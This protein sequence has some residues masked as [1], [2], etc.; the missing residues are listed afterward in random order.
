MARISQN[1]Q[2]VLRSVLDS[3]KLAMVSDGAELLYFKLLL[4][5]DSEGRYHGSAF[6]VMARALTAKA[7]TGVIETKMVEGWLVE[8]AEM[9]L[10]ER[11]ETEGQVYLRILDYFDPTDE[12]RKKVMFP[13]PPQKPASLGQEGTSE[14]PG[15][16]VPNLSPSR[17]QVGDDSW[18]TCPD[19]SP[20]T[21]T[22]TPT[23]HP[24]PSRAR[25]TRGVSVPDPDTP[26]PADVKSRK[27]LDD[28]VMQAEAAGEVLRSDLIEAM[29][30]YRKSCL[31]M[32]HPPPSA[33]QW[34]QALVKCRFGKARIDQVAAIEAFTDAD[35]NRWK[36][37]FPQD[38]EK[39]KPG[40]AEVGSLQP[41]L[42]GIRLGRAM[43]EARMGRKAL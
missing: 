12:N 5:S 41:A 25:E 10:I 42:D 13:E 1:Y 23:K 24:T 28:A 32:N 34:W 4:A 29:D 2:A 31:E 19:P 39:A 9:E 35:T 17:G 38:P 14:E 36:G 21:P 43:Y 18:T 27:A 20:L 26:S 15:Q 8:L 37:I 3:N 16:L 33:R 40:K 6:R 30:G 22:P 7:E 11:Y